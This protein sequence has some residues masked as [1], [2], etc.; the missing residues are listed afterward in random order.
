MQRETQIGINTKVVAT[1]NELERM[2]MG[3]IF[4]VEG[5]LKNEDKLWRAQSLRLLVD[6]Q[7]RASRV[8]GIHS[9]RDVFQEYSHE[10]LAKRIVTM[11]GVQTKNRV[12]PSWVASVVSL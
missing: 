1:R 5:C 11:C 9:A 7:I 8:L 3:H 6:S 12:P 4:E 10:G 2:L